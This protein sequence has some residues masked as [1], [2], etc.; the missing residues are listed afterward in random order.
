M[1]Y[2]QYNIRILLY[3]FIVSI[4]LVIVYFALLK[5]CKLSNWF[6]GNMKK[7]NLI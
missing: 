3:A 5:D 4:G 6:N 1:G 7:F 2:Q